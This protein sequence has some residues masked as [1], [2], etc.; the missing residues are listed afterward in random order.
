M[1]LVGFN[2]T[3]ISTEKKKEITKDLKV[4]TNIE[5]KN[6]EDQKSDIFKDKD[7]MKFDY[8]FEINYEPD[9][10]KLNFQGAILILFDKEDNLKE[11]K[12]KWKDKKIPEDIRIYLMNVILSRCNIRSL[13]LEEDLGIPF[14]IPV[15][16]VTKQE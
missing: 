15:P 4:N 6:I 13:Q 1:K 8:V 12:E 11:V 5:I 7:L 9:F 2:F 16:R 3:K 10:A 14:H